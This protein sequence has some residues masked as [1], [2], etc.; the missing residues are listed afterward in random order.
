M[1]MMSERGYVVHA[2]H[3]QI[4]IQVKDS[5]SAAVASETPSWHFEVSAGVP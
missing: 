5:R 2:P 1:S 4:V 3:I